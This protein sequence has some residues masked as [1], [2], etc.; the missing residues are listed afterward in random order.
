MA[1]WLNSAELCYN[2]IFLLPMIVIIIMIKF[3]IIWLIGVL[4]PALDIQVSQ[5][6][7]KANQV[8]VVISTSSQ[9]L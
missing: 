9:P 8:I 7:A 1:A 2:T 3:M 4:K 6:E 5:I